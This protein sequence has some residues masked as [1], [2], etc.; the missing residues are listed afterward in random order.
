[1]EPYIMLDVTI[2][3]IVRGEGCTIYVADDKN[4]GAYILMQNTEDEPILIKDMDY[5]IKAYT[6]YPFEAKSYGGAVGMV[7]FIISS[8]GKQGYKKYIEP[9]KEIGPGYKMRKT[10][11]CDIDYVDSLSN[12]N[13]CN[14]HLLYWEG[15]TRW[16]TE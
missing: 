14:S 10:A 12:R 5:R 16:Q 13:I 11:K 3:L 4:H 7:G 2:K 6:D 9:T 8:I 1:M 15:R